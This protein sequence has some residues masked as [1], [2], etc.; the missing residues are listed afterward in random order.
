MQCI[1]ISFAQDLDEND[2]AATEAATEA[3]A[4]QNNE[5][6]VA[7]PTE[8]NESVPEP[9]GD[10][11]A[12]GDENVSAATETNQ[13][14]EPSGDA[15]AGQPSTNSDNPVKNAEN[16]STATAN[17]D[18]SGTGG[19]DASESSD[20]AATAAPQDANENNAEAGD[21]AAGTA[22]NADTTS[23]ATGTAEAT[24]AAAAPAEEP[25]S[26]SSPSTEAPEFKCDSVGRF[27][28]SHS[29]EKYYFCWDTTGDHAVFECPH[30][31][32]FDPITQLCVHNFAVCAAAP[33]C[34]VDRQIAA[35][36]DDKTTFFECRSEEKDDDDEDSTETFEVRKQDCAD[37]REYDANLG[38]CTITPVEDGSTDD[39]SAEKPDCTETGI[40]I[41]FSN[42]SRYYECIVKS[43]A[44]GKLKLIHHKCPKY[45]VFSM[46]DKKCIPLLPVTA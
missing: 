37:G 4:E 11:S 20:A 36:P 13:S 45:H 2:T 27:A 44:K 5:N 23:D 46:E 31:R 32:A 18:S 39:S 6:D 17:G 35:N 12:N 26:T 10:E 43:V 21:N 22:E 28:C 30:H 1:A 40:S 34:E 14:N 8:A 24:T 25:S 38:Y 42:E 9:S 29:C 15:D 7:S 19:N 3:A 33:K 16:E 41:D